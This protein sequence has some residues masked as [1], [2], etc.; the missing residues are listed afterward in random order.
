MGPH[1][2][3]CYWQRHAILNHLLSLAGCLD[4]NS[5]A[6]NLGHVQRIHSILKGITLLHK[7]RDA[8]PSDLGHLL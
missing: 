7:S 5:T 8:T 4:L 2:T 3:Q 1:K 6:L